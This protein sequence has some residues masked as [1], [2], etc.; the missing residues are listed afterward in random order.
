MARDWDN[1]RL[2][3]PREDRLRFGY[4][5]DDLAAR[6]FT[7]AFRNL[8]Q[9]QVD[10]ARSFL[11]A[12]L[13]LMDRVPGDFRAD[14]ELFIR[15]GLAI[16]EA[17]DR[18]DYDVWTRRPVVSNGMKLRLLGRV[19]WGSWYRRFLDSPTVEQGQ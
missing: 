13:P 10:R 9:F 1:Q 11:V 8:M 7:P 12:G 3:L 17:I 16:L 19:A 6:R 5:S 4:G 2:Y 15:G 14:I 18:Q